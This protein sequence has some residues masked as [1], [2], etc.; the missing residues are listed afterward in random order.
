MAP[1]MTTVLPALEVVDARGLEIGG[2]ETT[3][4]IAFPDAPEN[5]VVYALPAA[6]N[7]VM[8]IPAGS[9]VVG[10]FVGPGA[11]IV[12]EHPSAADGPVAGVVSVG[13]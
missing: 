2:T 8:G 3:E 7:L 11:G 13:P 10:P 1:L 6:G 4:V 9:T 5:T 12:I